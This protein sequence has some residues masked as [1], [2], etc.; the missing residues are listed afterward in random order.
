MRSPVVAL[1]D[2]SESLLTCRVP[3]LKLKHVRKCNVGR[4]GEEKERPY[5][6]TDTSPQRYVCVGVLAIGLNLPQG[7]PLCQP[8]SDVSLI[9]LTLG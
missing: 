6:S 7:T 3:D 5:G 1:S 8:D 9:G 2:S 4:K